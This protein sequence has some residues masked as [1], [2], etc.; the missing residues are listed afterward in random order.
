MHPL[1]NKLVK[2]KI[3]LFTRSTMC[4]DTILDVY[5]EKGSIFLIQ[6]YEKDIFFYGRKQYNVL[7]VVDLDLKISYLP[8]ADACTNNFFEIID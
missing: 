3:P 1:V 4:N 2:L 7:T 5:N 8:F 6:N